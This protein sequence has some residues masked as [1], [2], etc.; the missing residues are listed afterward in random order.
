MELLAKTS[1]RPI[2]V[3]TVSRKAAG[4]FVSDVLIA[5]GRKQATIN[6][7]ISSLSALWRWLVKR[8]IV[9]VNPWIGQGTFSDRRH[10]NHRP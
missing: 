5:S 6:R 4:A 1:A 3:E 2:P 9:D 7:I 10:R 8:G